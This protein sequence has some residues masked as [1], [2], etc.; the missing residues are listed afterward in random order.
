MHHESCTM[1]LLPMPFIVFLTGEQVVKLQRKLFFCRQLHFFTIHYALFITHYAFIIMHYSL[2]IKSCPCLLDVLEIQT[3]QPH[4][5]EQFG[6]RLL[7][8]LALAHC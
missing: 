4:V 3:Q 8:E 2:C 1:F 7:H 6:K 5:A